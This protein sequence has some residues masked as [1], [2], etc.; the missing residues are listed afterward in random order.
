MGFV[1]ITSAVGTASIMRARESSIARLR[2]CRFDFGRKALL[3]ELLLDLLLVHLQTL[4][5]LVLLVGVV[6]GGDDEVGDRG[7]LW[8]SS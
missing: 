6:D 4:L 1:T 2:C 3:L 5:V 7:A 8:R